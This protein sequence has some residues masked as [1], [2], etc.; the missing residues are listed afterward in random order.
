V[1]YCYPTVALLGCG[2]M[3]NLCAAQGCVLRRVPF[4]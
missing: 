1:A 4:P 3:F 2:Q